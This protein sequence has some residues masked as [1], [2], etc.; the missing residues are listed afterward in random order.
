MCSIKEFF[1]FFIVAMF[2]C[3]CSLYIIYHYIHCPTTV[4]DITSG[5]VALINFRAEFH[6]SNSCLSDELLPAGWFRV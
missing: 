6:G 1:V 3:L 5:N 2:Q 4:W